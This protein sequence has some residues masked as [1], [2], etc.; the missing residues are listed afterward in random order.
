MSLNVELLE[1]SFEQIKPSANE[2]V[3][4]FY[5]TLF[6]N[7]PDA[8]SLFANTDMAKQKKKLLNALVLVIQNLRKP[9]VLNSALRGLGA[10][11]IAYG[12]LPEHYPLVGITLIKTFEFYLGKDWTP[13]LQQAWADAYDAIAAL[14]LEGA[15]YSE[16]AIKLTL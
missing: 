2:F 11:H 3:S 7:Y 14:M 5:T 15:S 12:T 4:T 9:E 16:E 13:E 8:A 1:Q 10:K 6:E